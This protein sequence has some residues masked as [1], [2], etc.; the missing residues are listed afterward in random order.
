MFTG[1]INSANNILSSQAWQ[2]LKEDTRS[3]LIDVRAKSELKSSGFPDLSSINKKIIN[4]QWLDIELME[5]N[6]NFDADFMVQ[7]PEK[8]TPVIFLCAIGKRSHDASNYIKNIGYK[9]SFN[10]VDGFRGWNLNNLPWRAN[11]SD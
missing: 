5:V 4:I 6:N 2:M 10:I 9:N 7:V 1:N 11:E 8:D 3:K